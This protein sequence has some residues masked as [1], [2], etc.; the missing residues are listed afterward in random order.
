MK[1]N[2]IWISNIW[3]YEWIGE[4]STTWSHTT[5]GQE[6]IHLLRWI[7][8]LLAF[9]LYFEYLLYY[10]LSSLWI[11]VSFICNN[12]IVIIP[13][14]HLELL[15]AFKSGSAP[16][17]LFGSSMKILAHQCL[18]MNKLYYN[19]VSASDHEYYNHRRS[20]HGDKSCFI[21]GSRRAL[22]SNV[23]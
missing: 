19:Y 1:Y 4:T 5:K 21:V 11:L 20:W 10:Y 9:L 13:L 15:M 14:C 6:I 3:M 8:S 12:D 7:T 16:S 2:S 23:F 17:L 22:F 18:F